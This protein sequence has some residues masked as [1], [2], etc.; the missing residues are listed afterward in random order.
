MSN[1]NVLRLEKY[2][3]GAETVFD[4]MQAGLK[5]RGKTKMVV[6]IFNSRLK[7]LLYMPNPNK[8]AHSLYKQRAFQTNVHPD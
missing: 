2:Q 6:Y 7:L 5:A 3:L 1:W 4:I 8:H